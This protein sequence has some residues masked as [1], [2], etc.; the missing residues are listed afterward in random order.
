MLKVRRQM[1][2]IKIYEV[3]LRDGIQNETLSFSVKDRLYMLKKMISAGLT[4]IEVGSFVS[5]K[6]IPQMK[7]SS[8]FVQKINQTMKIPKKVELSALVP[9]EYGF[10]QALELGLN[11]IAVMASATETFS[12]KN[13]HCSIKENLKRVQKICKQARRH[14]ITVRAYLSMAFYCPY[15]GP[16][17]PFKS[18]QIAE[19]L[20]N[21]GIQE[22]TLSDTIG[23]ASP[24]QV[25]SLIKVV[26]SKIPLFKLGLH[27][28]NTRGMALPNILKG[29][30]MGIR[31]LDS[32][33]GGLGGCPYAQGSSGNVATEDLMVLLNGMKI[34]PGVNIP[35]LIQLSSWLTQKKKVQLASH[36]SKLS[37]DFALY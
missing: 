13:T 30:Q 21:E 24:K 37:K 1:K 27:C 12:Q 15:E 33:I 9:N 10:N 20:M 35:R 2:K 22:L 28:H 25:E 26:Q 6:R 3:G 11:H 36:I 23:A 18:T 7:L 31:S 8:V 5:P 19:K 4:H 17:R 29:W 16:V 14:K 32:S 34:N